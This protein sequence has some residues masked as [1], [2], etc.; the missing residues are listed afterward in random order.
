MLPVQLAPVAHVV[1]HPAQL[2]GSF[3]KFTHVLVHRFG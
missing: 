1:P 3:V 2:L